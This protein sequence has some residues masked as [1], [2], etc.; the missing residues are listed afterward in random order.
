MLNYVFLP[1]LMTVGSF[2]FRQDF[3]Q[4]GDEVVDVGA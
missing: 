1:G 4:Q 3:W 2:L